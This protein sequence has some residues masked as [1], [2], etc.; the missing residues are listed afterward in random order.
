[1]SDEMIGSV[2]ACETTTHNPNMEARIWNYEHRQNKY[3]FCYH[4]I[5]L[6]E[7][8]GGVDRGVP[9]GQDSN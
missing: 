4:K 9:E 8:D 2:D 1:M 3:K 6:E 5:A 7:G